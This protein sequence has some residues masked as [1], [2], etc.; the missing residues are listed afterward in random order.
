MLIATHSEWFILINL[1]LSVT[2]H[3][4]VE[5]LY[6]KQVGAGAFV[7][8]LEVSFIGR[9]HYALGAWGGCGL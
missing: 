5:P 1:D 4:A 2:K 3:G 9:V 6:N 7:H 8:Y